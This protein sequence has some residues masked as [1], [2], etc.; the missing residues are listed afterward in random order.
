[1]LPR[2]LIPALLALAALSLPGAAAAAEYV[3][4][5]V[6]VKYR[7][8]TTAIEQQ[9][10]ERSSGTDAELPV[11]SVSKQLEIEDGESV[12]ETL[13]ELRRDPRV[14]YAV[15]NY[16]A[17]ASALIPND[18]GFSRQWNLAG[19]FGVGM[20]EAWSI[21]RR[22]GAP[23]G[24]GALVAVIDSG[25]AYRSKGRYRRAPDLRKATF[26]RGYDFVQDDRYPDDIYGHGTHVTGTIAQATNNGIGA[27]GMAYRT[28][29]MPLRALDRNGSG[30]S[31]TIARAIRYAGRRRADVINLSLDFPANIGSAQIPE[32]LSAVRYAHS[33]GSVV[34]AA[35]GNSSGTT[36]AYPARAASVISVGA[37][38][39]HGCQADYSNS[40]DDLDIVAP[41]GGFDAPNDQTLWDL[42]HCRTD[43]EGR[44]IY[45]QTFIRGARRF[46]LPGGYHG[47]SMATPHVAAAAALVI[48]TGRLGRNPSPGAV[49][50]HLERTARDMGA[51]ERDEL[52]GAGLLDVA[53][54]LR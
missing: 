17:H 40:G 24:R 35:A 46:G 2:P 6:V 13:A 23:G 29:I 15:P 49:E 38:T 7:D 45:Q 44:S 30:N 52:Y 11:T 50:R 3:P 27:A 51:P 5:E 10:V 19:E 28:R 4:G 53:A 41:G 25:V 47:T 34:V 8:G 36:L 14:A 12:P 16:V 20:P 22:R 42:Q 26:V 18:P 37:T 31:V 32:V 39:E 1:M 33:R 54:A 21:A 43:L 9:H 48:A